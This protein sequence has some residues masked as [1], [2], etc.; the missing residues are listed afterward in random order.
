MIV[1]S[2][3]QQ[4]DSKFKLGSVGCGPGV[5]KVYGMLI[6]Q[7]EDFSSSIDAD[8]K[9]EALESFPLCRVRRR[10]WD[11]S[12]TLAEKSPFMP[13]NFSMCWLGFAASPFFAFYFSHLHQKMPWVTV[14][15]LCSQTNYLCVLK[16][17]DTSIH[18]PTVSNLSRMPVSFLVY[19]DAGNQNDHGQ[20]SYSAALLAG[21]LSQ[22]S[23]L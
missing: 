1:E 7:L 8:D 16:E 3:L 13:V 2:I 10:Q 11:F 23:L 9:P 5:L 22:G 21:P 18:F 14:A 6:V 4:F 12:L 19:S 15:A 20:L 17:V